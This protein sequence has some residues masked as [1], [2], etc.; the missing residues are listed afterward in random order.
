MRIYRIIIILVM[1]LTSITTISLSQTRFGFRGG[2]NLA[3]ISED[4]GGTEMVDFEGTS[5]PLKLAQSNRTSYN[6]GGFIEFQLSPLFALQINAI[7]NQKGTK[8][9]G[10][11][12]GLITEQGIPVNVKVNVQENIK[13][14]YLSF[15]I[16]AKLAFGTK[17]K[18]YLIAGP[19][20]GFLISAKDNAIATSEAEA[21]GTKV[22]PYTVEQENDM[23]GSMESFDLAINFGAGLE[24]PLGMIEIFVDAQYSLGLTKV[25]KDSGDIKNQVITINTGLSF[26]GI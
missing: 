20:I 7:Y 10:D 26:S 23:K 14:T 16:L 5:L 6:I 15:P 3:N 19:E 2:L 24:I 21:M 12:N 13:L 18:P 17:I 25:N 22:G 1:T 4:L 11:L 8:T 9:K